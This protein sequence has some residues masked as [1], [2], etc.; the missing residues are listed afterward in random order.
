MKNK[1][2]PGWLVVLS[3]LASV[4]TGCQFRSQET[5]KIGV[6]AYLKGDGGAIATSGTPTLNAARLAVKEINDAGGVRV[7]A[8]SY[9]VEIVTESIE[10]DAVQ[11]VAAFRKLVEVDQVVAVVGPQYSGDTIAVG[12]VADELQVPLLTGTATNPAVTEGRAYV[13]RVAYDDSFQGVA[14]ARFAY[15]DLSL[16]KA[17][18][19]SDAADAYSTGLAQYFRVE[20]K[21]LGGRVVASE[22]FES[23]NANME[24]QVE[25]ILAAAPDVI[26]LPNYPADI[27]VQGSLIRSA[28]FKGLLL[29]ADGW[30]ALVL[31]RLPAFSGSAYSSITYSPKVDTQKNR[32]FVSTFEAAYNKLPNDGA[33]LTYD[34]FQL[35]FEAIR[36]Q[37]GFTPAQIRQGLLALNP[38]EGVSGVIDYIDNGNARKPVTILRYDLGD[39]FFYKAIAP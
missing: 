6:I 7:G 28:G 23:G 19:L 34:A 18:L 17:A 33:G 13:F 3:L 22:N 4:V 31:A 27:I 5:I 16:R 12:A 1:T 32:T 29:G 30:D 11:A 21:N 2:I 14:L 37:G 36:Q 9:Q 38:Y 25:R 35:I 24:E 15:N 39:F 26:F 8:Q 20:F 10:N